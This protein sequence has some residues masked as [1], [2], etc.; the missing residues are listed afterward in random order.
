M[1]RALLVSQA[2]LERVMRRR[3]L[4]L[5]DDEIE[6]ERIAGVLEAQGYVRMPAILRRI[7]RAY[8]RLYQDRLRRRAQK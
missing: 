3:A 1:A 5:T 8:G 6:L 2:E 7:G 4:G